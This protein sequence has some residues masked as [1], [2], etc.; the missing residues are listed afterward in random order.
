MKSCV[1]VTVLSLL[2][3][4]VKKSSCFEWTGRAVKN[5]VGSGQVYV[6]LLFDPTCSG[7]DSDY[8]DF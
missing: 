8:Q 2:R 4:V 5:L 3:P 1:R 7:S 6:R